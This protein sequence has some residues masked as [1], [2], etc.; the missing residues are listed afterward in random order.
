MEERGA[1]NITMD[2]VDRATGS[3]IGKLEMGG[4]E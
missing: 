2:K 3:T 4:P 1:R